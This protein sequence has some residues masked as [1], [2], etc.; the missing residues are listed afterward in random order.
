MPGDMRRLKAFTLHCERSGVAD[1]RPLGF[2][3]RAFTAEA[4]GKTR[5]EVLKSPRFRRAAVD[6]L[7]VHARSIRNCR[8]GAQ[9]T[10]DNGGTRQHRKTL[11]TARNA[12]LMLPQKKC[13]GWLAEAGKGS[14]FAALAFQSGNEGASGPCR[15]DPTRDERGGPFLE[16]N[17]AQ[18][19]PSILHTSW[20]C[21]H[22]V[23]LSRRDCVRGFS[24][25]DEIK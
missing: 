23:F 11:E 18:G 10:V 6:A 19:L 15:R 1:Q 9:R 20:V 16:T 5:N 2:R 4:S 21:A 8:T 7:R 13:C 14:C 17:W 25:N 22:V 24:A 12:P 3:Q